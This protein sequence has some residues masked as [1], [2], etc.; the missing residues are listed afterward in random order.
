MITER[1]V[2]MF[3]LCRKNFVIQDLKSRWAS[4]NDELLAKAKKT[5]SMVVI[6]N[7]PQCRM[8]QSLIDSGYTHT[9]RRYNIERIPDVEPFQIILMDIKGVGA[10][11]LDGSVSAKDEGLAVAAEI[12]RQYPSKSVLVFSALL[13]D[14]QDHYILRG[15]DGYFPKEEAIP[16][17][18]EKIDE[19]L[20]RQINPIM[21]WRS[22]RREL[23]EYDIPICKVAMLESYFV[24]S[25]LGRKKLTEHE[26]CK[27][28]EG[29]RQTVGLI[30]DLVSLV[31]L[32]QTLAV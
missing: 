21:K 16:K 30:K 26:A 14:Y 17:R 24:A 18:N 7:D 11:C 6:D 25:V 3:N 20:V 4:D 31:S 10:K 5:I 12:K 22:I 27:M 29:A 28:L 2:L 1:E 32:L 19:C 15:L 13:D 9:A 23:L 8:D